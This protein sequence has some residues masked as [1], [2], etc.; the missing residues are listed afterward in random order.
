MRAALVILHRYVGLAIAPLLVVAGLT[1]SV[2]TF[3][4]ELERALNPGLFHVRQS[5]TALPL[6]SIVET[7]EQARP[8]LT[9]AAAVL[10]TRAQDSLSLFV[11]ARAGAPALRNDQLFIDPATGAVLGE[12]HFGAF[13]MDA[14]HLLPFLRRVHYSLHISGVWG[15]WLMGMAALLWTVDCFVGFALTLPRGRPFWR[16]WKPAWQVKTAAAPYRVNLDI[17]RAGGLWLWP[18]LFLVALSSVALN[19]PDQVFRPALSLVL[20]TSPTL[21][22]QPVR[23]AEAPIRIDFGQALQIAGHEARTGR[24][25]ER[26]A[27]IFLLRDR[28]E[29]LVTF[30]GARRPGYGASSLVLDASTGQVVQRQVA[31][32]RQAGDTVAD[33]MLPLHT[34]NAA[35]LPG[36]ILVFLSGIAVTVLSITGVYLW[37]KKRASRSARRHSLIAIRPIAIRNSHAG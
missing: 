13:R 6:A 27:T 25:K 16:K 35:G 5:G 24:W 19:L 14:A 10:P 8:K 15:I 9:V 20:P 7:V 18:V 28:G 2:L 33:L 30:D 3:M 32:S 37:W 34:G 12:R 1:G 4:P 17:H 36:R 29:Y 21:W 26:P 11:Q 31:G 22:E 23:N